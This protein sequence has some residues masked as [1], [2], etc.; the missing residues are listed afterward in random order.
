MKAAGLQPTADASPQHLIRRLSIDLTGLPPT[1]EHVSQFVHRYKTQGTQAVEALVDDLLASPH[2]G[3]RW[4]RHWLDV[5]RYGESNG[6]DGLGRNPTFPHAWRYR[7]YVIDA[8][9]RDMP[10][11][12]FIREQIA[13]DLLPADTPADHDRQRIATAFLAI[14]SKPAKAMN[15]NF[16]MDVVADQI[17]VVSRGLMGLSVACA[18]CHDHKHD[19]IPTRDYYALAGIFNSTETLWGKAANEKLTAP[20]TDLHVL[21]VLPDNSIRPDIPS[22]NAPRFPETYASACEAMSPSV[23]AM[24]DKSPND[25]SLQGKVSFSN[26]NYGT[27]KAGRLR[28][29]RTSEERDYSVSFWFRNNIDNKAR[30]VTAYLHSVGPA[31]K[32][33]RIGDH[34]GISGNYQGQPEG[35]LFLFNGNDGGESIRGTTTLAPRSWHHVVLVRTGDHVTAWLNGA[36]EPEI[37]GELASTVD[38]AKT[39]FVGRR[40]DNFGPL[41]GSIAAYAF[42]ERCLSQEEAA[43]LHKTSGQAIGPGPQAPKSPQGIKHV[44]MG[45]RENKNFVDCKININGA[46]KKLGPLVPR[47]FLSAIHGPASQKMPQNQ[48]G[49][50][51]LAEWLCEPGP[52]TYRTG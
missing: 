29:E 28:G 50:I 20:P 1:Q 8:I 9:N 48:S 13:G 27:F 52:S 46:A 10:Y 45:V 34:L 2:F 6:N 11:D 49:R 40:N 7:D 35:K 30:P 26:E 5:A 44:A 14:G 39:F 23:F 22:S 51:E 17:D 4:G 43:R 32:K 33:P 47:G 36:T 12:Q 25:L 16:A 21:K 37:D 41:D 31:E 19:P 3:E 15:D 18:R 38:D 42:F 24:L